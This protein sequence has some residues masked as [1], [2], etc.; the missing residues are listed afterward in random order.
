[1]LSCAKPTEDIMDPILHIPL[2]AIAMDA[3]P[4]D[5]ATLDEAALAELQAS[6]NKDGLRQPIEVWQLTTPAD[7]HSYG[8]ISGLRRLTVHHNL[9]RLRPTAFTTI[10]AFLRNPT[11]ISDAMAAMVA[12][13][14]IRSDLSPWDKGRMLVQSVEEGIFDT[15]EAAANALH[16]TLTRQRRFVL[17]TYASVVDELQGQIATP[18]RLNHS[19]LTRLASALRGGLIDLIRQIFKETRGQTLD[20]QWHALL[21]TLSEADR[22]DP[23]VPAT[24]TSPARP[25]RLLDLKQGLTI[26]RELAKDGWI[27]RF[28]GDEA[29]KGAL[30]DDVMDHVERLFQPH[31]Q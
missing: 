15:I 18:E 7:G 11:S 2:S 29:R 6:V 25:R 24:S 16:P 5:R 22:H 21:P 19:Q 27:L 23:E 31:Y 26:R 13:N 4:R 14:E 12:E 20:H 1:M 28:T 30:M 8:L 9:N 17:R 10:P 3:L